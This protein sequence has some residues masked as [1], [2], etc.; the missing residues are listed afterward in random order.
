M[1]SR[2]LEDCDHARSSRAG[3]PKVAPVGGFVG[4]ALM[5]GLTFQAP[6]VLGCKKGMDGAIALQGCEGA[7]DTVR[8]VGTLAV[9]PAAKG[10]GVTM[11]LTDKKDMETTLAVQ[12]EQTFRAR[13]GQE[14]EVV[15]RLRTTKTLVP[16][17]TDASGR[18][19]TIIR[20]L[21][22]SVAVD[23]NRR[24]DVELGDVRVLGPC[25]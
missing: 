4:L 23:P 18:K 21:H 7:A 1:R 9:M 5:F 13:N 2:R 6:F 11:I 17:F 16:V 20:R 19:V 3:C 14:I 22:E 24:V 10:D 25:K 8:L 12:D 15:G